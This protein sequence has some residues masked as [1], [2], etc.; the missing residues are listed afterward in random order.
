MTLQIASWKLGS[1]QI[2]GRGG[3]HPDSLKFGN[4]GVRL[5]PSV[6]VYFA[7]SQ[8]MEVSNETLFRGCFSF[9][10]GA[11]ADFC[12]RTAESDG[13]ECSRDCLHFGSKFSEGSRRRDSRR[14]GWCCDQ[15][16]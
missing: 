14:G 3:A 5:L 6:L 12:L 8:P 13:T 1:G 9:A 10:P 2:R 15:F 4:Q 11:L 7:R 16:E